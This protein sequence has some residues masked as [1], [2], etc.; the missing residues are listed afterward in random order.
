[1][2]G[3]GAY[4]KGAYTWSNTSVKQKVGLAAGAYTG[5]GRG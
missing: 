4:M 3:G 5:R 1:M 2:L